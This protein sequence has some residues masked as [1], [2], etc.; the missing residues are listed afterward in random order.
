MRGEYTP[1][2]V[3]ALPMDADHNLLVTVDDLKGPDGAVLPASAFD[4][5]VLKAWYRNGYGG[6]QDPA[7]V[8]RWFNE[9]LVKDDAMITSDPVKK[10]NTI[11]YTKDA[12]TLQPV[13]IDRFTTRQFWL[14]VHVP[15][16]QAAGTYTGQ[17]RVSEGGK[18]MSSIP[19]QVRVLPLTLEKGKFS[20]DAYYMS[21]LGISEK[22]DRWYEEDLKSMAE[23]GFTDVVT[24]DGAKDKHLPNGSVTEYDFSTVR[25][26]LELR[27]KYG[28]TGKTPFMGGI[29]DTPA[30]NLAY[31]TPSKELAVSPVIEHNWKLYGQTFTALVKEL[32]FE[33]GYM[34]ACDE[35]GYDPTGELMKREA[36][37]CKW[38]KEGGFDA[39]SAITLPAAETI[40]NT[41]ALPILDAP[42]VVIGPDRRKLPL[43]G[44]VWHY[45]HPLQVPTYDRLMAGLFLWYGGYTGSC[46]WVYKWY[47]GVWDEWSKIEGG[48]SLQ[49]YVFPGDDGPVPTRE[50]EGLREGAD[51]AKYLEMLNNRVQALAGHQDKLDAGTKAAWKEAKQIVNHAPTQF[52]GPGTVAFSTRID[53]KMLA[54]FRAQVA[55]LL[56]KLDAAVKARGLKL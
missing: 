1:A 34:Y 5:R 6:F 49:N 53:G 43:P 21:Q 29:W 24:R 36:I 3:N 46:P 26:A 15:D 4:L 31:R 52:Q 9:L 16:Q 37:L 11:H 19:F 14:T 10:R 41:L 33:K 51:D 39:V 27:K 48:Y 28:L 13:K 54:A 25:R 44:D 18:A 22:E 12:V 32:G 55:D 23:H 40:K 8:G 56:V 35:P 20:I 30:L 50:Y 42:S 45:W 2:C 7:G 38:S 17:I 47:V